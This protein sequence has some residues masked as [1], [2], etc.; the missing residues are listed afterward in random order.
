V[1]ASSVSTY[2]D[3]TKAT[4]GADTPSVGTVEADSESIDQSAKVLAAI[5]AGVQRVPELREKTGL[6]TAQIV[7]V[8]AGLAKAGLVEL[9][10]QGGTLL[11]QLTEPAKVALSST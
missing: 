10:D 8:L 6:E 9:D 5:N 2:L 1:T 7:A 4:T 11:A 3:L